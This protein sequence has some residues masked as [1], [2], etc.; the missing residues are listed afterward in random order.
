MNLPP[1]KLEQY[2]EQY[3]FSV[4]YQL[5]VS[6][7]ETMPLVRLLTLADEEC[8]SL[9]RNL[10]LGY[11]EVAG[12]PLLRQEI[13][14]LYNK[15]NANNILVCNGAGEAIYLTMQNLIN[16]GDHVIVLTPCYQSLLT[17]PQ[18][19]GAT[20]DAIPFYY[21]QGWQFDSTLLINKITNNT[22]LIVINFPHNPTGY[23]PD[24]ALFNKIL[25]AAK[26]ANCYV[27]SDEAYRF[28]EQEI[29]DR[30]PAACDLYEKAISIG[31]MSKPFG[32]PGLRIGWLATQD[33]ELFAQANAYKHYISL[34]SSA[35]S[36]ILTLIALRNKDRLLKNT[37]GTV[38]E[39]LNHLD[40]FFHR[41]S[42][43]FEWHRPKAGLTAYPK[44]TIDYAIDDL[45]VKLRQQ[46]NVLLVPASQF[47]QNNNHFRIGFGRK[48][49]AEALTHF[50]QFIINNQQELQR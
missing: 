49:L 11:T 50:E 14:Q 47:N 1:F 36:E 48:N 39:N 10:N 21:E 25:S 27:L 20:I 12:L 35:P 34:C 5:S 41:W 38:Q 30:L 2:F 15:Q 40:R 29:T 43:L 28:S 33:Q 8:L 19:L 26:A 42:H 44:L 22:K 3:E 31:V 18:K 9:W 7:A 45:A 23:I 13:A 17:L 32:L 24:Q 37:L 6:D 4:K 16:A 46:Q